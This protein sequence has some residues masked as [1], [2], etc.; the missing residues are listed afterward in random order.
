MIQACKHL[1]A[2]TPQSGSGGYHNVD[3]LLGQVEQLR[4]SSEPAI[5]LDEMLEI[6]DTEGNHQNGGG[7][8]SVK[9]DGTTRYVK[10]EPDTNSAAS[11]HR[12]SLVPGDIGS[13]IP[14]NSNP[15]AF[16]GFGTPSVLRQYSS[17]PAGMFGGSS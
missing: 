16:G 17:P 15:A 12:G 8:F 9:E 1:N 2:L 10:F 11:G 13:P 6:C 4:P 14:G 7:S 5:T 3:I